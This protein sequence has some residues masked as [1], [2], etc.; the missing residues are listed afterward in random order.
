MNETGYYG[1]VDRATGRIAGIGGR[2]RVPFDV[3]LLLVGIPTCKQHE[4]AI[5]SISAK[6]YRRGV[7][8][9]WDKLYWNGKAFVFRA[10]P[11]RHDARTNQP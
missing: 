1:I 11:F 4:F 10:G 8:H 5:V 9:Q 3:K 2:Y 6:D 7:L